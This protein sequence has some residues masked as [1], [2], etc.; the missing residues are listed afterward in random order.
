[1]VIRKHTAQNEKNYQPAGRAILPGKVLEISI[2]KGLAIVAST[3]LAGLGGSL[4][5]KFNLAL[6]L[7]GRVDAIEKEVAV[8]QTSFMP[9][10]LSL[11]KWKNSDAAL[12][13]INKKLDQIESKIDDIRKAL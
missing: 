11:E 8:M 1:M 9:L 2:W 10:N 3:F 5:I 12:V 4:F 6:S 13:T 7:P